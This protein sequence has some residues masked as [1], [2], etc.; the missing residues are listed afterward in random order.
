LQTRNQQ[1]AW[2]GCLRWRGPCLSDAHTP[3][4]GRAQS[5]RH[6][7]PGGCLATDAHTGH[8]SWSC[9]RRRAISVAILPT[10]QVSMPLGWQAAV[11]MSGFSL[12]DCPSTVLLPAYDIT[13]YHFCHDTLPA[14]CDS[15]EDRHHQD[16]CKF[17][18]PCVHVC[19]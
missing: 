5:G 8:R 18:G 19:G 4:W 1:S 13:F 9:A 16:V 3:R 15:V 10:H 2:I 7:P 12:C 14:V 11:L 6:H 17:W